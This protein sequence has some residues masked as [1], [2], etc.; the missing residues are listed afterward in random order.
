MDSKK[1]KKLLSIFLE[2]KYLALILFTIAII[3]FLIP[4]FSPLSSFSFADPSFY[5]GGIAGNS[6]PIGYTP[7]A[8]FS[9]KLNQPVADD[10]GPCI[11]NQT[12]KVLRG[13]AISSVLLA[14][15]LLFWRDK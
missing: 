13:I 14:V 2:R 11:L 8:G 4:V 10:S 15:F 1:D 3:I 9:E 7:G 6:C 12:G 5:W